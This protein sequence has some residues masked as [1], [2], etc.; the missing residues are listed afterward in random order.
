MRATKRTAWMTAGIAVLTIGT[1][2][3]QSVTLQSIGVYESGFFDE[4]AAEIPAYDP[5]TQRLFV[6]NATRGIDI[7]DIADPT[8]PSLFGTINA[9][10]A[11]SVSVFGDTL[12][13]A[14]ANGNTQA[15]GTVQ[16]FDTSGNFR[17]ASAAGALPDMVTFTPNGRFVLAANEGEPNDDYTIDPEGSISVID[18]SD[19][20]APSAQIADFT[21]FNGMEDAFNDAGVRVFGPGASAAQDFEP[22]YVAVSSDSKTA[23]VALQENNAIAEVDIESATVTRVMPLGFKNHSLPGNGLDANKNDDAINIQPEPIFGMY[24]PDAISVYEQGG[25]TY[26]I[27]ANEGDARDYDGFEEEVDLKDVTLD[28][29]AFS[30]DFIA[31]AGDTDDIGDLTITSTRGDTDGDGDFDEIYAYGA[32]SFSVFKVTEDGLVRAFDSGDAFEQITAA[33]FPD[34][35]NSNNDENDSIDSRSDNKGPEPEALALGTFGGKTIAFIGLE[36]IGGIMLYDITDPENAE[37]LDYVNERDFSFMGDLEVSPAGA[38]DLGP[39]GLV[40]IDALDSPTGTPLLVAA[41]E[42]SGTTRI[43][44]VFPEPTSALCM[45]LAGGLL[46]LRRRSAARRA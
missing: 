21:A 13:V 42:M 14:V 40:F 30:A 27:T 6:V 19:I 3:A 44:E 37:F 8:T 28:P 2:S 4:S 12:A 38:G 36:R 16:F 24:Q 22:E 20:F 10:G 11:N 35:F 23:Y 25:E 9:P 45:A 32:R 34:D 18:V 43:Y 31:R 5:L 7:L 33:T 39:E 41:N 17:S 46:A 26:I 15:N 29:T 1:A